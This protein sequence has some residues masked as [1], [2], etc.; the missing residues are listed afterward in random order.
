MVTD[1]ALDPAG[2]KSSSGNRHGPIN[3]TTGTPFRAAA[4]LCGRHSA[5][6]QNL[7]GNL[8]LLYIYYNAA[9][10]GTTLL[11]TII[12][13]CRT[14]LSPMVDCH[15]TESLRTHPDTS[16]SQHA[17][18]PI[19]ISWEC[20]FLDVDLIININIHICN[21]NQREACLW[22]VSPAR[23]CHELTLEYY[24]NSLASMG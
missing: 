1:S 10:C 12:T 22:S 9:L 11:C 23:A 13:Q 14:T 4:S 15:H 17:F 3:H 18:V 19:E 21:I 2:R 16:R 20:M 5:L 8:S 7:S 24:D 6:M